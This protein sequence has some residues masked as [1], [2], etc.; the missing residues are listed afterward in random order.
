MIS[1][2]IVVAHLV[3]CKCGILDTLLSLERC[4]HSDLGLHR[5]YQKRYPFELAL[6]TLFLGFSKTYSGTIAVDLKL[7]FGVEN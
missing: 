4:R 1:D 7:I 5:S 3:D 6:S 2:Y